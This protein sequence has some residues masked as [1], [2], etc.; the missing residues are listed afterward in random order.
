MNNDD[1][2]TWDTPASATNTQQNH[3]NSEIHI[4]NNQ[5]CSCMGAAT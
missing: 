1:I 5:N 4:S 2:I 3:N